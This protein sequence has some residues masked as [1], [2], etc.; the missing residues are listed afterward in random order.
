MGT[1]EALFDAIRALRERI[2]NAAPTA[3]A[4]ELAYLSTAIEKIAGQC[5]A[6]DLVDYAETLKLAL[7]DYRTS[8]ETQLNTAVTTIAQNASTDIARTKETY[9]GELAQ[10]EV[11]SK[12]AMTTVSTVAT[13]AMNDAAVTLISQVNGVV[14]QLRDALAQASDAAASIRS[15]QPISPGKLYFF[16][17]L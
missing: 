15:V 6:L 12:A 3:T 17:G 10:Q 11:D 4:E 8:C 14:A 2:V 9:L 16:S 1:S 7:K 13:K 5:S